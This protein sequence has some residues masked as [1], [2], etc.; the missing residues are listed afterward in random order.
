[1]AG[2]TI[3]AGGEALSVS[4]VAGVRRGHDLHA[5]HLDRV[6][7]PVAL[8]G[9]AGDDRVTLD[10]VQHGLGG[11]PRSKQR[12]MSSSRPRA[13]RQCL[14]IT[15]STAVEMFGGKCSTSRGVGQ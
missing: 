12:Q 4:C 10:I 2:A 14:N 13:A 7:N 5:G 6:A 9:L 1:V 3:I 15:A 11:S 8:I